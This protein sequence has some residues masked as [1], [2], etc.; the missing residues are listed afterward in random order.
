MTATLTD[1][2]DPAVDSAR[3]ARRRRAAAS[4]RPVPAA[5]A[6]WRDPHPWIGWAVTAR[7][8]GPRR[9]HPVLGTR[10]P[11][12]TKIFDE[13]YYAT[14]SQEILRYGYEDN[15]GYMFIVHGPGKTREAVEATFRRDALQNIGRHE[16]DA[17]PKGSESLLKGLLSVLRELQT[18]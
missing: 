17:T 14:E 3:R 4:T 10:L 7:P 13:A 9:V 8:D 5:L 6:P 2:R 1:P 15:R 12:R 11:A 16:Q 18:G